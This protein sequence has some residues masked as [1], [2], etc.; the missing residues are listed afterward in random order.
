VVGGSRSY[1][2]RAVKELAVVRTGTPIRAVTRNPAATGAAAVEVRD[3][4]DRLSAF[5]AV[6][7]ATH[8]DQALALL[9]DSTAA[10][11]EILG[12]FPYTMNPAVLHTDSSVL[13][14]S[15]RARAAWNYRMARCSSGADQVRVSYDLTRLQQL[16]TRQ[17]YLVSLNVRPDD[18]DPEQVLARM[19]YAHPQF[20]PESVAAQ[21]ELPGLNDGRTA[22]AGAYHGWGFHEDG[23]RSGLAAAES[24]GGAW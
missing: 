16:P 8:P 14:S 4:A 12:A 2:D 18:V 22:F 3:A 21:R 6:V 7:V 11:R 9:A 13:P 23:A 1:V 24:I 19:A 5:D 20:T 15:A 10:E 17:R